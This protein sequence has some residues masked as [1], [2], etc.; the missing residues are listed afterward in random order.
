M[1][2]KEGRHPMTMPNCKCGGEAR[3]A[4]R[5]CKVFCRSCGTTIYAPTQEQ[6]ETIWTDAQQA[7]ELREKIKRMESEN[8]ILIKGAD[9]KII[10]VVKAL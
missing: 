2:H 3:R 9:G 4:A 5:Y 10:D 1:E 6:A 8:V 7:A